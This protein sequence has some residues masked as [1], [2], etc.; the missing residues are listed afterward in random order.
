MT[1]NTRE[2]YERWLENASE[3]ERRTYWEALTDLDFYRLYDDDQEEED[4][5]ADDCLGAA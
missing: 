4:T 2:E 1:F 3:E 5:A